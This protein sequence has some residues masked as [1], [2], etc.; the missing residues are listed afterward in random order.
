MR[1]PVAWLTEHV[2]PDLS[3][4]DLADVLSSTGTLVE[5]VHRIGVPA[6]DGNLGNFRVGRVVSAEPHPNADRLRVCR[7]DVGDPRPRQIVCGAPNVA[8]GQTVAVALP[9]ALLPGADKPLKRAKLRGEESDGMILSERE[10]Q[11]GDDH[12]GIMV[13]RD[14]LSPGSPLAEA[15][16][17]S[18]TVL[19]LEITSNRPDCLSLRG[20]A[21]EVHA[22]TGAPLVALDEREPPAE[23]EGRVEDHVTL[24]VRA[25]DL[26]PR[27]MARVV[28]DVA[29]G[30]SPLWMRARLEAAGMRS[31]SNVVDITNY[32][33]LLTG[34]PLHAFD[35]DRLAGPSIVVRR[36]GDGERIVTL[37]GVE[38]VLDP[39]MLAICD[40][41]RPAVIAG[42]FGAEFAEVSAGTT[43]V[44][45]E[46]ANFHGPSI[47]DASLALGLRTES[48]SRFEKGL[49]R[50]L[51]ARGMAVACRLLVELA[52]GRLVPGALDAL[53]PAPVRAPVRM[54]HARLP[55]ILGVEVEPARSVG[56]L[57]RLGLEVTDGPEALTAVVPFERA[58]D[59][60]REIDLI[61]EVARING[62]D[63]VP[64]ELPRL[65]GRGAL[66]PAQA[67]ERRL[68]RLA[69]DLGLSE[70]ISHHQVPEADLDA[71]LIADDDP[72]RD[73]VR[74]AHP[75]SAEMAVMRRSM[76]PGLLRA[77][78]RNQSFQRTDGGLFEIG[79]TFAP[80]GDGL[81]DERP[82]LAAVQFGR[83]G[84]EGWRASP[85]PVD[86]HTAVGLAAA[87]TR[88]VGVAVAPHPNQAPYFHPVRQARLLAGEA[89]VGW[90]AEVHPLVL[91]NFEVGGPVAA[92]VLALDTLLEA[93]P[94][95]PRTFEDLLTVP[96]STRDLAMVVAE[97]VP[98]AD[99]VAAARAAG[100]PLVRDVRV[101]DR[102]AGE[103]VDAGHVSLALR[104][105]LADPGRTLTD[106]EIDAAVARV[107][108]AL[109]AGGARLRG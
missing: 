69:A 67:L 71:L 15:V 81:A 86:V 64:A 14:G 43:R 91:R 108:E 47:L 99:L 52:G 5:E 105:T 48:S 4:E 77:V 32:V 62:L 59:L 31:I 27:Y 28:T 30:P 106:D 41:E 19:E 22:A 9:G 88:A 73:L 89:T 107:R 12:S 57:E 78:A 42:V 34:Q 45:L 16:P 101:F 55:R 11:L 6:G 51:P 49:P 1:V 104:L 95:E 66:S 94:A 82:F 97:T 85:R 58:A 68:S 3:I 35:L 79:R 70:T 75:M 17:L 50:E 60:T 96:V 13:L 74:M 65:V 53:V 8:A 61:E 83:V 39:S 10:L 38:R 93:V 23:G 109:E 25:P 40:A 56:I 2:D 90:A 63:D 33:M 87:L 84:A 37:D 18:D 92:V 24:D 21:R 76:L 80:R 20:I 44:L 98:S 72:R 7:V 54:R 102:Y 100:A 36:A 46:A 29:V 103:Q 26:C